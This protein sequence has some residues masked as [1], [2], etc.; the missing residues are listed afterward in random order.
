MLDVIEVSDLGGGGFWVLTFDEP[1]VSEL[2]Q[3][4]LVRVVDNGY[5]PVTRV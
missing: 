4:H 3:T 1:G 2:S 5:C